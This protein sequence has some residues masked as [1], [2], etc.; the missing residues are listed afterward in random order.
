M[1]TRRS[2]RAWGLIPV[3]TLAAAALAADPSTEPD[4]KEAVGVFP[5]EG[6]SLLVVKDIPGQILVSTRKAREVRFVS[7]ATDKSGS[8]RPL[9]I[10]FEG[11]TVTLAPVP[12]API[13]EGILRVEV[14]ESFGV[15][16]FVKGGTATVDGLGGSVDV[17]ASD[18]EVR[19]RGLTGSV[20]VSVDRGA[21]R[22]AELAGATVR[23][24]DATVEA[25]EIQGPLTARLEGTKLTASGLR[26]NLDLD[27]DAATV[28]VKTLEGAA[29][30]K[31]RGGSAELSGLTAGADFQLSG[32]PLKLSDGKGDVSVNSDSTVVFEKMAGGLHFDLYGGN[33]QGNGNQGLVEVRTRN[34][35]IGLA[36]IDG[37]VRIQG[38]GVK[39]NVNDVS[40]ELYVETSVSDV[41]IAKAG[42]G[43]GLKIERGNVSLKG[44]Q[45]TVS[46]TIVGGD[47]QLL[48]LTGPVAME[49]E[50]GNAEVGWTSITGDTDTLVQNHSGDV[51]LFVP[52]SASCRVDATTKFGR[53]ESDIPTVRVMDDAKSAQ[54]PVGRGRRPTI[55]VEAEGN[56]RILGGSGAGTPAPEVP[57]DE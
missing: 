35:E 37:P 4:A 25:N 32:C 2:E 51:T 34:T 56:V 57:P 45:G 43:V 3:L 23:A 14:P 39:V 18:A 55:K 21:L 10:W 54:G 50:G 24:K 22:L 47:A 27:A 26:D 53:I 6:E 17:K 33:L 16:L 8:D 13:P 44:A 31:A 46:A 29:R 41:V 5:V 36:A 30:V 1:R 9:G 7:R 15:R 52:P 19:L 12:G 42:G 40:G 38:D 28:V 11:S 20:D 48:D 49:I